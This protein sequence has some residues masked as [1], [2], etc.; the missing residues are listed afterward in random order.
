MKRFFFITLAAAMTLLYGCR[1]TD[2]LLPN[3][4]GSI[5]EVLVVIDQKDW[6]SEGGKALFDILNE[7]AP[8]L[9]QPEALFKLSK[10]PH[11]AFDHLV[12]PARNIVVVTV[13][14]LLY[15]KASMKLAK[16]KW[17]KNQMVVFITAPNS[18]SLANYVM[19]KK[20]TIQQAFINSERAN[21]MDYYKA[22]ANQTAM[23]K[24]YEKFGVRITLPTDLNKYKEADNFLWIS[25]GSIDAN[26]NIIIYAYPY[27]DQKQ[28]TEKELLS[29]RDSV[30]KVNIP[31]SVEGSYMGTEYD[32]IPPI[33]KE[34]WV[35]D[36]YCAEIHGLWK[37]KNGEVMGG[38]F[39]SH[40][41]V[42]ELGS[43]IITVE[44]FVFAPGRDKLNNIRQMEAMVYSLR[45]PQEINEIT[46][47]AKANTRK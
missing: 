22:N 30:L 16:N 8:A 43:R 4:I 11:N 46:V 45:L 24:A 35:N 29:R 3:S 15:T 42:D 28:L 39:V 41:R 13:D 19:A 40:S 7:S 12:K 14:S 21:Q 31:G 20:R 17:A 38:P 26:K 44:G 5:F 36:A 23:K 10:V 6:K 32:V 27:T 18:S 33:M 2:V 47:T 9:P 1:N 34:I 25:N 37:M